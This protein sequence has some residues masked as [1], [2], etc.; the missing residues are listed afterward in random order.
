[1]EGWPTLMMVSLRSALWLASSSMCSRSSFSTRRDDSC[2]QRK[3]PHK[4]QSL[5]QSARCSAHFKTTGLCMV[6]WKVMQCAAHLTVA[7]G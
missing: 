6:T 1:M 2:S 4:A 7:V 5:A 3:G